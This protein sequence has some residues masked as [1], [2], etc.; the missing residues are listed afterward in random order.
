[1]L[2]EAFKYIYSNLIY[3]INTVCLIS[4]STNNRLDT[5]TISIFRSATNLFSEDISE[6]FIIL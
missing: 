3:H 1:M 5:L 4:K 6:N 2:N